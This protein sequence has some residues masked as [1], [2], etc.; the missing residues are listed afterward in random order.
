MKRLANGLLITLVG[1]LLLLLA[2]LI[3]TSSPTTHSYAQGNAS[4]T[5]EPSPTSGADGGRCVTPV[6]PDAIPEACM[7]SSDDGSVNICASTSGGIHGTEVYRAIWLSGLGETAP[8]SITAWTIT[9]TYSPTVVQYQQ[10]SQ[11]DTLS[12]DWGLLVNTSQPGQVRIDAMNPPTTPITRSGRLVDLV[13]EVV[14]TA[15]ERSNLLLSEVMV[16]QGDPPATAHNGDFEVG[17]A[18]LICYV[19]LPLLQR[20]N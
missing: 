19:H 12:E 13:F 8:Y 1:L 11:R 14:G 3:T 20:G 18:E 16:N 10:L 15:G 7:G 17:T 9:L 2:T 6:W 4:P 5:P